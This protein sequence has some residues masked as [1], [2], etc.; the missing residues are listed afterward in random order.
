[1]QTGRHWI[2]VPSWY[3]RYCTAGVRKLPY[4]ATCTCI[5]YG[6]EEPTI[7]YHEAFL[8]N[9]WALPLRDIQ[10]VK[11]VSCI[12]VHG[13]QVWMCEQIGMAGKVHNHLVVVIVDILIFGIWIIVQLWKHLLLHCLLVHQQCK[14]TIF[15]VKE[16]F[17]K[18][19]GLLILLRIQGTCHLFHG[20]LH[21]DAIFMCII[22]TILTLFLLL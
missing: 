3:K 8:R 17:D 22:V 9:C 1:M 16:M 11:I 20:Q 5:W 13:Q 18:S 19:H 21:R 6:S 12:F 2:I 7:P 10:G 14:F 4:H 15:K